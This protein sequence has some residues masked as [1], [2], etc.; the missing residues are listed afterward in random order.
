MRAHKISHVIK[1]DE[2]D[3]SITNSAFGISQQ[4]FKNSVVAIQ[5][6]IVLSTDSTAGKTTLDKSEKEY[7]KRLDL[8]FEIREI[9]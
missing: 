7:R 4:S 6:K 3:W 8:T 9:C 2:K 1:I 5:N